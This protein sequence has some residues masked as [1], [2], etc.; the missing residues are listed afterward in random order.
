M[1]RAHQYDY[2][3]KKKKEIKESRTKSLLFLIHTKLCFFVLKALLSLWFWVYD[4]FIIPKECGAWLGVHRAFSLVL[5]FSL[6][7]HRDQTTW[8]V[9]GHLQRS[10]TVLKLS[11]V[12]RKCS[13]QDLT[14]SIHGA[15]AISYTPT[16][17]ANIWKTPVHTVGPKSPRHVFLFSFFELHVLQKCM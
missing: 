5:C 12:R 6:I 1:F 13:E 17:L 14:L 15:A 16:L 3:H 9:I 11:M 2:C 10:S 8:V 4:S 7:W